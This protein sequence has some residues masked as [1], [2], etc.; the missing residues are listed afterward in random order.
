VPALVLCAIDGGAGGELP[1]H[2]DR[3]PRDRRELIGVKAEKP[4]QTLI[5]HA[6]DSREAGAGA[7]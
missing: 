3:R 1:G 2:R 4:S 6:P 7:V 5:V